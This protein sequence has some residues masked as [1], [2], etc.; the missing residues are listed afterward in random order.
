MKSKTSAF[1]RV[2]NHLSRRGSEKPAPAS[3]QGDLEVLV[4][5]C[6]DV[7]SLGGEYGS[8]ELSPY[9]SSLMRVSSPVTGAVVQINATAA[10]GV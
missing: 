9:M 5:R 4:R 1:D 10:A 7:R 3:L 6:D 2:K 8:V